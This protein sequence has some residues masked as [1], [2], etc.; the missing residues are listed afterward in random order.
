MNTTANWESFTD[1]L[2]TVPIRN[3]DLFAEAERFVLQQNLAHREGGLQISMSVVPAV[4]TTAIVDGGTMPLE[5]VLNSC[6]FFN[7]TNT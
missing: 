2:P 3:H 5:L 7:L 4:A 1:Q 6:I